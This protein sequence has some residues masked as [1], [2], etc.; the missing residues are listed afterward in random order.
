MPLTKEHCLCLLLSSFKNFIK[1]NLFILEFSY[2][3]QVELLL[4]QLEYRY[5]GVV[6][7]KSAVASEICS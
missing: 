4:I 3:F 7:Y 5:N 6:I 1:Y 2:F